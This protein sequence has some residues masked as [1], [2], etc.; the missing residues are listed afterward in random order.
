MKMNTD[1]KRIG[2]SDL[3]SIDIEVCVCVCVLLFFWYATHGYW[4]LV[5]WKNFKYIKINW[6]H[7]L[8]QFHI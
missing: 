4:S 7:W 2:L 6:H 3:S 5:N 8:F 1:I